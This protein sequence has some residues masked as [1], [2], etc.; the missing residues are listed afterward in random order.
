MFRTLAL[1]A[2]ALAIVGAFSVETGA[3]RNKPKPESNT[4]KQSPEALAAEALDRGLKKLESADRTEVK[5]PN[6][7]RKEYEAALKDLQ[8]AV[9]LSPR[10]YRAHNA[11]GYSYRKLGNYE[12]ALESY[13]EALALAPNF[14]D[15]IEYRAEAYLGLNRLE[16]AK[17][18]YMHLFVHDRR[19]AGVLMKAM[20]TWVSQRHAA[21]AGVG[22][23]R[24][25]R[26]KRWVRERDALAP[27][28]S[29]SGTIRRTGSSASEDVAGRCRPDFLL[30]SSPGLLR[31]SPPR[32][33]FSRAGCRDGSLPRRFPSTIR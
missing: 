30:R 15:A 13:E 2:A 31:A 25:P 21:P 11:V 9:K 10:D 27:Q 12:R 6:Q 20:K 3:I 22:A 26:S 17:Q 8:Q 14:S 1:V 24:S 19:N 33:S 7:A 16:E 4:P 32:L 28:R 5:N 23:A 29:T 18:A